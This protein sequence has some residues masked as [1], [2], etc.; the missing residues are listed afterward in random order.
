MRGPWH[1]DHIK[2]WSADGPDTTDNLRLL[3]EAHNL[4]RSNFIDPTEY[5]PRRPATWWCIHCYSDLIELAWDYHHGAPLACPLHPNPKRCRVMRGIQRARELHGETP[6]WHQRE[7]VSE[8]DSLI[9]AYCAHCDA[10]A[11]TRYPL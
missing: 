2:P 10:P 8:Q 7:P 6:T 11:L 3:C 9:V 4:E 5:R 1:L